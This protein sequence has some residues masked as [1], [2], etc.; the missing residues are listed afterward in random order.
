MT[1][2]GTRGGGEGEV[3]RRRRAVPEDGV[4]GPGD[5]RAARGRKCSS[6]TSP[7]RGNRAALATVRDCGSR[8]GALC[9][10][11]GRP[12]PTD[13]RCS[14]SRRGKA[15]AGSRWARPMPVTPVLARLGRLGDA[16]MPRRTPRRARDQPPGGLPGKGI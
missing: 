14:G 15:A 1:G 5:E 2:E 12:V 10:A 11:E 6:R 9:R 3:T 8:A 4:P 16:G 7:G 13:G